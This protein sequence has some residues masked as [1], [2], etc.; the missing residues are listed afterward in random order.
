M[1]TST[2]A[3]VMQVFVILDSDESYGVYLRSTV[4]RNF[5]VLVEELAVL[6]LPVGQH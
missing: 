3:L 6:N 1:I 5:L 4:L 2:S